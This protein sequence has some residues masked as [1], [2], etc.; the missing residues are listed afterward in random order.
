MFDKTKKEKKN[1][2]KDYYPMPSNIKRKN[3][4][5]NLILD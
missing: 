2:D 1:K 5:E 4:M 3:L